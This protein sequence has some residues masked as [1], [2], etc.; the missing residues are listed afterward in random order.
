MKNQKDAQEPPKADLHRFGVAGSSKMRSKMTPKWPS[1]VK[2]LIFAKVHISSALPMRVGFR[3]LKKS[4]KIIKKTSNFMMKTNMRKKLPSETDFWCFWPRFGISWGPMREPKIQ[5]RG[6]RRL[7]KK[8]LKKK[9]RESSEFNWKG[10]K[11]GH[12]SINTSD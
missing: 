6:F 8:G 11:K 10:A 3:E 12:P 9:R 2:K 7:A 5:K 1:K 4:S